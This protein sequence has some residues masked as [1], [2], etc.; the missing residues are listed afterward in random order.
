[1]YHNSTSRSSRERRS[2]RDGVSPF[3]PSFRNLSRQAGIA[4]ASLRQLNLSLLQS[5]HQPNSSCSHPSCPNTP[6]T[7]RSWALAPLF[8]SSITIHNRFKRPSHQEQQRMCRMSPS[9][10]SL[11]PPGAIL[12]SM[13]RLDW[14]GR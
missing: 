10:D 7:T 4:H 3:I 9:M 14:V 2:S 11:P 6:S 8:Q 1:M 5:P 13:I 12:I